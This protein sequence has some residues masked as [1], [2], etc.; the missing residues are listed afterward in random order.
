MRDADP[1]AVGTEI[2]A[3]I[4]QIGA[5]GDPRAAAHAQELARLLMSL[6][7]AGLSRILDIVRTER[8]GGDAALDRFASDPLVASLLV[9]HDLHPHPIEVRV[10]R[11]LDALRPH[12]PAGTNVTVLDARG[13]AV[14]V[15]VERPAAG[16]ASA[17]NIHLALERAIQEAAPE[18][19]A[20]EIEGLSDEL[21]Q[22]MRSRPRPAA[23]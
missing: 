20:I 15:R 18:A 5:L 6:Y 2:E 3:L 22:I 12:L 4:H 8:A 1:A 7:G 13:D 16:Q 9:L 10:A 19:A 23:S 21:I 14:R 11:A 17:R